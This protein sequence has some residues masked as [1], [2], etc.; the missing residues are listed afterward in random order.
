MIRELRFLEETDL[1]I[2]SDR[3][4]RGPYG[5]AGGESGKPGNNTLTASGKSAKLPAKTR[6]TAPRGSTLRIETPG[7]GGFGKLNQDMP[8]NRNYSNGSGNWKNRIT[9]YRINST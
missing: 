2:L 6:I 5:L 4:E 3:R 1:T 9:S 8:A 7:G